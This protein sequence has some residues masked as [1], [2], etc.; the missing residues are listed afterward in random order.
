MDDIVDPATEIAGHDSEQYSKRQHDERCQ[1]P[2]NES[3]ADTLQCLI[4]D[5][6]THLVSAEDMVFDAQVCG[7]KDARKQYAQGD[8]NDIPGYDRIALHDSTQGLLHRCTSGTH[9]SEYEK[10]HQKHPHAQCFDE[11][12]G[13]GV[14]DVGN[15]VLGGI[16]QVGAAIFKSRI[17]PH[18]SPIRQLNRLLCIEM[19]CKGRGICLFNVA[20]QGCDNH[21]KEAQYFRRVA[22]LP[23][24]IGAIQPWVEM[25]R[26]E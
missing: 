10:E 22:D 20:A 18:L 9:K 13:R 15:T 26:I 8:Q 7:E 23:M 2:N 24:G 17:C 5:I 19:G 21:I 16:F 1:R 6:L 4:E 11:R 12:D 3:G 14:Q 25:D